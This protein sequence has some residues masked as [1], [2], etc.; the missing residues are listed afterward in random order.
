[1][2]LENQ[3][4]PEKD[5]IINQNNGEIRTRQV[6]DREVQNEYLFSAIPLNG[7]SIQVQI[8]VQDINDNAP[9]F[10]QNEFKIDIPENI[11]KG[12]KRK[13]PSAIGKLT[14]CLM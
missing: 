5:L 1:M 3:E 8:N 11:P 9:T 12:T 2:P 4:N 6:L 13:L 7:E 14:S 10:G